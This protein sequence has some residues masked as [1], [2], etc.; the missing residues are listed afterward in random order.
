MGSE[1]SQTAGRVARGDGQG[2]GMARGRGWPGA[3]D[4]QVQGNVKGKGWP[5]A[6]RLCG[7]GTARCDGDAAM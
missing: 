2:Q 6:A 4:G 5:G 7:L 3:G 1:A